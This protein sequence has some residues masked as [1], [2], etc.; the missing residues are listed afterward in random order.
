MEFL[1]LDEPMDLVQQI[2][3]PLDLVD[4][5]PPAEVTGYE[6]A[7]A[8]RIRRQIIEKLRFQQVNIGRI[9]ESGSDPRGFS[10][11][12]WTEQEEALTCRRLDL[13]GIHNSILHS[14]LELSRQYC[15]RRIVLC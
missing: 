3:N 9:G 11:P 2:G 1:G 5:D 14:I 13:S 15:W 6:V 7:E 8:L 10:G 12:S 4:D